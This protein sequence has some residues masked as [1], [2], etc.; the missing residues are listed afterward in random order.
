MKKKTDISKIQAKDGLLFKL[1]EKQD[2]IGLFITND[3]K[4]ITK[5]WYIHEE[6]QRFLVKKQ[7]QQ[8]GAKEGKKYKIFHIHFNDVLIDL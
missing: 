5:N 3:S 7:C 2:Y 1:R 6:M 4:D 8:I